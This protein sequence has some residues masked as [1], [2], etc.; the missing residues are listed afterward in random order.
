[1]VGGTDTNSSSLN[2]WTQ[3]TVSVWI[4]AQTNMTT[5]ARLIEKGANDEWALSFLNQALTLENLGTNSVAITTSVAVA[6]T[7]SA[8]NTTNNLYLG[9]Y[10][11]GGYYYHG[12]M[13]EVRISNTLRSAAWI[14]T[15]Y[16]NESSPSTFLSEGSQQNSGQ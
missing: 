10:G 7:S 6:D 11:G 3:Q 8:S 4:N 2:G 12:L 13:D 1:M 14:A 5:Y 9:E 15:E 16:N